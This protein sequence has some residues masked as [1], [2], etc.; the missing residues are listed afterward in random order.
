MPEPHGGRADGSAGGSAGAQRRPPEA[1]PGDGCTV[2]ELRAYTMRVIG[3]LEAQV[4]EL[5]RR[6]DGDGA[7]IAQVNADLNEY[8]RR[9]HF[10][11][12]TPRVEGMDA[13]IAAL[14]VSEA[15][16]RS[17]LE[18]VMGQLTPRVEGMDA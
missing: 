13:K 9:E 10:D 12:L 14:E 2:D 11:Q 3:H 7:H 5:Q 8:V 4:R 18:L 16:L 15:N 1:A 17:R 6:V